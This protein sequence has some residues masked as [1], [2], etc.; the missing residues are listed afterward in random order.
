MIDFTQKSRAG[1]RVDFY[2]SL[3]SLLPVV[4]REIPVQPNLTFLTYDAV[5]MYCFWTAIKMLVLYDIRKSETSQHDR[6]DEI[7][8]RVSYCDECCRPL[9]FDVR[10]LREIKRA[11]LVGP[12]TV[13]T[14]RRNNFWYGVHC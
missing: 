8:A 1:R 2:I 3:L 14:I 13:M 7:A 9:P 11:G 5:K 6:T 12:K 10:T 4:L